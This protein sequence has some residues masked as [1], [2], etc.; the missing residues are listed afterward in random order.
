MDFFPETREQRW[1]GAYVLWNMRTGEVLEEKAPFRLV[2]ALC[3]K[4]AKRADLPPQYRIYPPKT[5]SPCGD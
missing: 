2:M 5:L 3:A 1:G 4:I